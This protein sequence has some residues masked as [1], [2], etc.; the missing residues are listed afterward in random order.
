[1]KENIVEINGLKKKYNNF[2]A[3]NNISFSIKKGEGT[4]PKT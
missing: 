3:V 1:M 4:W 2:T